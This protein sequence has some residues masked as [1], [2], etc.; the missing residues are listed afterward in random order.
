MQKPA[1]DRR[2]DRFLNGIPRAPP[3]GRVMADGASRVTAILEEPFSSSTYHNP[4]DL[5]PCYTPTALDCLGLAL[6]ILSNGNPQHELDRSSPPTK[7]N[8]HGLARVLRRPPTHPSEPS[9]SHPNP[10]T[11]RPRRKQQRTSSAQEAQDMLRPSS[12][13]GLLLPRATD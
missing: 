13:V 4:I 1:P 9:P 2:A 10:P 12:Y 8:A 3:R 7:T 5:D 11:E 6:R